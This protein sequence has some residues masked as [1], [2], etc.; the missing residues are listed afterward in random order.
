MRVINGQRYFRNK[1]LFQEYCNIYIYIYKNW[2]MWASIIE[3][4]KKEKGK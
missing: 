2:H 3:M 1:P 4:S